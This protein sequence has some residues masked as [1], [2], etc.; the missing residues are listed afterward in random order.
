[1]SSNFTVQ[2]I[3]KMRAETY[4]EEWVGAFC[5]GTPTGNKV[6]HHVQAMQSTWLSHPSRP[7]AKRLFVT[8][9]FFV[10]YNILR[11]IDHDFGHR[12]T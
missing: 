5:K 1:M 6:Q 10:A 3:R 4:Y 9:Y 2:T 7:W 8:R 11:F 12:T